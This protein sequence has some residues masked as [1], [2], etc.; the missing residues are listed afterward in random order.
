MATGKQAKFVAAYLSNG[1]NGTE[2]ARTAGY[3]GNDKTL[4]VVAYENLRKPNVRVEIDEALKANAMS[5]DEVLHR[6]SEQARGSIFD[7][8]DIQVIDAEQGYIQVN[9]S[10]AAALQKGTGHLIQSVDYDKEGRLK[11]KLY[12]AQ[13]ALDML[14]KAH[15]IYS[16]H[17]ESRNTDKVDALIDAIGK[18]RANE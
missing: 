13:T 14:A 18:A 12:S 8:S 5:R 11:L 3:K 10:L 16:D 15:G 6:I 17:L 1:L 7:V 9:P 2:A 4:A